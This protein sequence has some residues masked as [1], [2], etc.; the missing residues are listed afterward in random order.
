MNTL[1]GSST[2]VSVPLPPS[3]ESDSAPPFRAGLEKAPS[4]I[5][6][7]GV[8]LKRA[9][10]TLIGHKDIWVPP[11]AR[12]G[13][14]LGIAF[15]LCWFFVL[16]MHGRDH[17]EPLRW[18]LGLAASL[19]V[20]SFWIYLKE[21]FMPR[22]V[23][24]FGLGPLAAISAL[25][26]LTALLLPDWFGETLSPVQR[27]VAV[28]PLCLFQ[29]RAYLVMQGARFAPRLES[30]SARAHASPKHLSKLRK[31]LAYWMS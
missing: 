18:L 22:P 3:L 11:L 31:R 2:Q 21:L 27:L 10:L 25:T 9:S 14:L 24:M 13:L 16:V 30:L 29:L 5:P 6:P 20:L 15:T 17:S 8:Q 23:V 12:E 4:H 28:L 7:P 19:G 26:I 1:S